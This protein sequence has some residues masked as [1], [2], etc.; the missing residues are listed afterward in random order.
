MRAHQVWNTQ[1]LI[2]RIAARAE[3]TVFPEHVRDV[4]HLQARGIRID[5]HCVTIVLHTCVSCSLWYSRRHSAC[6]SV[7]DIAVRSFALLHDTTRAAWTYVNV[8]TNTRKYQYN[9]HNILYTRTVRKHT[10][11]YRP[12][13]LA[14]I[15]QHLCTSEAQMVTRTLHSPRR[16]H[17]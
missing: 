11:I 16:L 14:S 7:T 3:L 12:R 17:T 8:L 4:Q 13:Q 10:P 1:T 2:N 15:L 5:D 6:S 9:V